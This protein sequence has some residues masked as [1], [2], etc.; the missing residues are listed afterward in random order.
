M[1]AGPQN[2]VPSRSLRQTVETPAAKRPDLHYR[3]APKSERKSYALSHLPRAPQARSSEACHCARTC[4]C[5]P[6][7]GLVIEVEPIMF[8]HLKIASVL[9]ALVCVSVGC[10]TGSASAVT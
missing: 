8:T 9:V 3:R 7:Y 5:I 2:V 4:N 1:A 6:L 10:M